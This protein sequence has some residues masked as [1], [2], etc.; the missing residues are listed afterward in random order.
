MEFGL[1]DMLDL[2]IRLNS[3]KKD[4]EKLFEVVNRLP[5]E[6]QSR[7]DEI[8]ERYE[9]SLP[10]KNGNFNKKIHSANIL[11]LAIAYKL[12]GKH[13]I[14]SQLIQDLKGSFIDNAGNFLNDN[15]W[16]YKI[17][18]GIKVPS[19]TFK[20]WDSNFKI[21]F[22][23]IVSFSALKITQEYLKNFA[24]RIIK[25]LELDDE[26]VATC[27][28]FEGVTNKGDSDAW[29][30]IYPKV[31]KPKKK[32]STGH[33]LAFQFHCRINNGEI[34]AGKYPGADLPPALRQNF[35][36][37]K[38]VKDEKAI[39]SCFLSH[40]KAVVDS[41]R[42]YHERGLKEMIS[43]P[44][45]KDLQNRAT[46]ECGELC[47]E[48]DKVKVSTSRI[49]KNLYLMEQCKA[50]DDFKC[51]ACNFSYEKSI[52]HAHHMIPFEEKGGQRIPKLDE[53]ITLCPTCHAIAHNILRNH[54]DKKFRNDPKTLIDKINI[55]RHP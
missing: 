10:S 20:H 38:L 53:L 16:S 7:I 1:K 52:V 18:K 51:R 33:S 14:T 26:Y 27:Y 54:F 47:A 15:F 34:F 5:I 28:S 37:M 23:F 49:L 46:E 6:T 41:N 17:N 40:K 48:G 24:L 8:V 50:R 30:S 13:P 11:R 31:L 42:D 25:E 4:E 12:K 32:N 22:P 43:S 9:N 35:K 21:L 19:H 3:L 36:E 29:F 44:N 39:V 55:I 2:S 45:F